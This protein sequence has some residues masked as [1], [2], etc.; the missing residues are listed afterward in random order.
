MYPALSSETVAEIASATVLNNASL[1]DVLAIFHDRGPEL[2]LSLAHNYFS[3]WRKAAPFMPE[4]MQ[5]VPLR[6][7]RESPEPWDEFEEDW[8]TYRSRNPEA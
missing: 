1:H 7:A 3:Q 5:N 4:S 8:H 2:E 6:P